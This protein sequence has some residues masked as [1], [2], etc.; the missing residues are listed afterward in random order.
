MDLSPSMPLSLPL[1][2][3]ASDNSQCLGNVRKPNIRVEPCPSSVCPGANV[4]S[5]GMKLTAY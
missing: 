5:D 1:L 2:V 4:R 3:L